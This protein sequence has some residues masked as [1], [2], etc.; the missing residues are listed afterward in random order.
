MAEIKNYEP[1]GDNTDIIL[2]F[3]ID[4][5]DLIE[6]KAGSLGYDD[7]DIPIPYKQVLAALHQEIYTATRLVIYKGKVASGHTPHPQAAT[8]MIQA[9]VPCLVGVK[10]IVTV[11]KEG[12]SKW[13]RT[14]VYL[15]NFCIELLKSNGNEKYGEKNVYKTSR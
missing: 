4:D 12:A 11:A 15:T 8:E 7:E 6:G 2:D 5:L 14:Y 10:K 13:A 9:T 1:F 3:E